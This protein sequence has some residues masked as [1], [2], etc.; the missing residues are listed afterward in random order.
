MS[1][2]RIGILFFAKTR[3]LAGISRGTFTVNSVVIGSDLLNQLSQFF[4]LNSVRDSLMLALNERYINLN[5]ELSLCEG[6]EIAIIPPISG[7]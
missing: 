6:D 2:V 5:E 7:G 1:V 3:E 4:G